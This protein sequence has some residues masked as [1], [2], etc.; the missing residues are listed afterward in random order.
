MGLAVA[1]TLHRTRA[2]GPG[3]R[4]A[5]WVQGCTIRCAGCINPHLFATAGGAVVDPAVLADEIVGAKVEGVTLLGGEPFDQAAGCAALAEVLQSRGLG[6]I[7]FTGYQHEALRAQEGAA[8][9][10]LEATD[11]LVD[12]PYVRASPDRRRA[13]V[14]SSNQRFVHLT[15][16]YREF[17]PSLVPNRVDV[18]VTPSGEIRLAGFLSAEQLRSIRTTS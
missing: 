18:R 15:D 1:R 17:K 12:G 8:R 14:G 10:L 9:R 5:V 7:V 2:E 6:V 11:L 4:T 16:R 13:L 3:I